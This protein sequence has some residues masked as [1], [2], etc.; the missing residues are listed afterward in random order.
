MPTP[1]LP[2]D[3][4]TMLERPNPAVM[5]TVRKDGSPVTAATWYLWEDG[6]VLLNLDETRVR[7]QHIRRDPRVS[8][9]VLAGDDW[10]SHI[11]LVGRITELRPDA[12]RSDI[13]RISQ[14]YTGN[15]YPDRV[16]ARWSA[17]MEI[18]RWYGWGALKH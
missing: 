16:G 3:V 4:I 6:R 2:D 17:W 13:D 11:T 1:P 12:D 10:H 18:D 8:L 14:H 15:A 9:T 5:A 7:L